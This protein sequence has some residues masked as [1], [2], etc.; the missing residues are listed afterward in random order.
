MEYN[1]NIEI[2]ML[3]KK[4]N[5]T[6]YQKEIIFVNQNQNKKLIGR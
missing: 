6:F 2:V 1:I 5:K 4:K 3:I